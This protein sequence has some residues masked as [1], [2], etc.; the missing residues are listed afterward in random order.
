MKIF[1]MRLCRM[2]VARLL[3]ALVMLV[4]LASSSVSALK[5]ASSP[6][7]FSD[8][9]Y[10]NSNYSAI[11]Y[12]KKEGVVKGYDDGSYKPKNKINRAEFLKIVMEASG[13]KAEGKDCYKDVMEAWYSGYVC[14][15]T[16]LGVVNGYKDGYFRPEQ[17]IN[18]VE[19]AKI[20][21][22]TM[23]L[24]VP[25]TV[26]NNW[27]QQYVVTLEDSS[28]VP[29]SISSFEHKVTRGEMAEMVWRIKAKPDY[30]KSISYHTIE[31]KMASAESGGKLQKFESCVELKD[32]LEENSK[33]PE[34]KYLMM[35]DMVMSPTSATADDDDGEVGAVDSAPAEKS[36]EGLGSAAGEYSSTNVQVEGVDEADIV[37]ND[38]KFVYVLKG[39][40]VRIINA[41]PPDLMK[42]VSKVQFDDKE[43]Y[44]SDMYVDGDR[45]VVIGYTYDSLWD[46]PYVG[47]PKGVEPIIDDGYYYGGVTKMYVFD[48]KDKEKVEK[49]RELSYEGN[50]SSSR[51]V[52]SM[53]YLVVN[54]PEFTYQFPD[55]W[56][57]H[58]ILPLYLDSEKGK[59]DEVASC[60]DV[61]Y[62]PGSESTNYIVVAGVPIDDPQAQAVEEVVLGSS[63]DIYSSRE[64]LY[65]AEQK[66]DW[67]YSDDNDEEQTIIHKFNLGRTDVKYFGK[68]DVPGHILNQFS[69]DEYKGNFRI[70]T[71]VGDVWN[72]E[73]PSKN[74]IYILDEN[75]KRVGNI[76]GIAPGEKIYSV[77]F[78]GDRAYM[79]TFKKVDP[80]FV[81]DVA[82]PTS[83]KIL[84]KLKIPGYSD[85]L[86][87]YDENHIIGFGKEAVDPTELEKEGWNGGSFDF[88]WYQGM[89]IAMFD[90]T[91]VSNP[92]EMFKAQIGDRGTDSPLLSDHKALLFD[93]DKGLM[94]FP[95]TVAEI[96]EAKKNDPNTAGNEYGD[97]VYQGAYV[98][99]VSLDKGFEFKG[100]LTH[101]DENEIKDKAGYYWYGDKDIQR[102][103]YLGDYLYTVS[104]AMLKANNIEDL[105][106]V[107]SLKLED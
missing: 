92:V 102:V 22:N 81:I 80:F 101:Y 21:V 48:I 67:F 95:V 89:K 86:H 8:V 64:N 62:L 55:D 104:Q 99:S 29:S 5:T 71:T 94:A 69:M 33:Q 10:D 18:F 85:Y 98:Y 56:T 45:L 17:E 73:N 28:A 39:N 65:V 16:K 68:S 103:L 44:P 12:L 52:G 42:E 38:N 1:V 15:A 96:S 70:A 105:I 59:V 36:S 72:S 57:K 14:A 30:V 32:Y 91:D 43:F 61:L 19:A 27:Y 20:I 82:D 97:F 40:T 54:K 37:K 46:K 35:E 9:S 100:R 3:V 88:A 41:Y 49:L 106:E 107:K 78:M 53:V 6:G 50:Y 77:R 51:K 7:L 4:L 25:A 13:V 63:G 34:Y 60:G 87:P 26:S 11:D 74:N 76:E 84:G 90:V 58:E 75:L 79:V 93:K 23:Q 2:H 83:P 66:Y 31:K 24:E 47:E